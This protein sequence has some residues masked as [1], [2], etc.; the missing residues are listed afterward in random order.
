MKVRLLFSGCCAACGLFVGGMG[1]SFAQSETNEESAIAEVVR[2]Q[3]SPAAV[4]DE[5]IPEVL[6]ADPISDSGVAQ[7]VER[8]LYQDQ[9]TPPANPADSGAESG[10]GS[11]ATMVYKVSL[12]SLQLQQQM[13]QLAVT[14]KSLSRQLESL[15][16]LENTIRSEAL[17]TEAKLHAA[18]ES[19]GLAIK[20]HLQALN[21]AS[22]RFNKLRDAASSRLQNRAANG[23]TDPN[24]IVRPTY[25]LPPS[26]LRPDAIQTE[27]LQ[28]LIQS[29]SARQSAESPLAAQQAQREAMAVARAM[30]E[31]AMAEKAKLAA[32]SD[33]LRE[34][35]QGEV[36]RVKS[37][38][39]ELR[40]AAWAKALKLQLSEQEREQ[41]TDD[42]TAQRLEK[43]ESRLE[44]IEALLERL[45]GEKTVADQQ[46]DQ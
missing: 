35:I 25:D 28:A 34:Q 2:N 1:P 32:K 6:V 11:D 12:Q 33:E 20:E 43:L 4:Q 37:A 14:M 5:V 17:P 3:D 16:K 21:L 30:A 36:A 40:A 44:R 46:D 45:A 18:A 8:I 31:K 29:Q 10:Q 26:Q 9:V 19:F 13:Q 7:V 23:T 39:E 41:A 27:L 42:A 38:E 22:E 24:V 15:E